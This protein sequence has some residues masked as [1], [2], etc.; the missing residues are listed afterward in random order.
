[1]PVFNVLNKF[2]ML[3][4]HLSEAE[5]FELIKTCTDA[6]FKLPAGGILHDEKSKGKSDVV[7]K[8]VSQTCENSE[9]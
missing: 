5:E 7:R 8:E 1:M 9:T 2:S 6:V 4:P 3:E